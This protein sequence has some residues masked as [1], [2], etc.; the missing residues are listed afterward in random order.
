MHMTNDQK[1]TRIGN[2]SVID[3]FSFNVVIMVS[4]VEIKIRKM[5]NK[6]LGH[7]AHSQL[8]VS[9]REVSMDS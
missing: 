9:C 2:H 5:N 1:G 7:I 6:F 4:E 3:Y 8:P